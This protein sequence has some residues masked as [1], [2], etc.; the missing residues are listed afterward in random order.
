MHWPASISAALAVAIGAVVPALAADP[1]L[2]LRT[3]VRDVSLSKRT[4][5]DLYVTAREAAA[6]LA[7]YPDMVLVDLR[8][9]PVV[10]ASGATAVGG[11][12][13]VPLLVAKAQAGPKTGDPVMEVDPRFAEKI[14]AALQARRLGADATI[15]MLCSAGIQ[16]SRAADL[17]AEIG[18]NNVYVIIDGYDGNFDAEHSLGGKGWRNEELTVVPSP[19][20]RTAGDRQ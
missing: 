3:D 17:L 10:A 4:F 1:R 19:A 11:A 12:V 16:S 6:A 7:S 15:L 9:A 5:L 2:P 14:K 8:P 18:Y 20:A 13:Q